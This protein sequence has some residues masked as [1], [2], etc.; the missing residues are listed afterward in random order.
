MMPRYYFNIHDGKDLPDDEGIELAGP[1][2]AREQAVASA[3]AMLKEHGRQFW[4]HG[5]WR[6]NVVDES[7]ATVCALRFAAEHTP[8]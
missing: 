5:E 4:N 6:M 1:D 7:G 2:E 3:G 8:A